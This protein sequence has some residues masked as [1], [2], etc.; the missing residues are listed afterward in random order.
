MDLGK[1]AFLV[2]AH[3][4]FAVMERLLYCLDDE[5]NDIYIHFDRKLDQLPDFRLRKARLFV[6]SDRVDVRWGDVSMIEAEYKLFETAAR[7]QTYAYY[8]VLSGVDLPLKHQDDL[9]A[10]FNYYQGKE[11]IGI[12]QKTTEQEIDRKVRRVHLYAK[13]FR[14]G[15]GIAVMWYRTIRALVLRVQLLLRIKR[16]HDVVF[17]K[18]PQWISVTD[19]FVRYILDKKKAVLKTYQKTFCS[20]EIFIQTLCWNSD[21]R[22]RLFNSMQEMQG[23]QRIIG[24]QNGELIEWTDA[25]FDRLIASDMLFA[26][27]F[28]S[29]NRQLLE[30]IVNHVTNKS[31]YNIT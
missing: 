21:F 5:R 30:R 14:P 23:C 29:E 6:L 19:D 12:S 8:H 16:N 3:N 28:S 17:K 25:D 15:K 24:W 4:E 9:H 26:R 7:R 20:D 1:H 31:T 22:L 27:K 10:F 11:F 13:L 2:L 18:G